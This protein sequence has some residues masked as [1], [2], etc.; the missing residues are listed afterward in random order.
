MAKEYGKYTDATGKEHICYPSSFVQGMKYLC[1]RTGTITSIDQSCEDIQW[2]QIEW[3]KPM[4]EHWIID[5]GSVELIQ[6]EEACKG[7]KAI[8]IGDTVYIIDNGCIYRGYTD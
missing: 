1:G 8:S 5:N 4:K 7:D 2:L 6:G 3:D